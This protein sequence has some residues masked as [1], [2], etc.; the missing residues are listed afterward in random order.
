M[1]MTMV[2][3]KLMMMLDDEICDDIDGDDDVCDDNDGDEESLKMMITIET[4]MIDD[5]DD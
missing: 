3:M 4:V 5:D 2:L 1:V